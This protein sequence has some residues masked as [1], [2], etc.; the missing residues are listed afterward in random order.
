M[1]F[2][3]ITKTVHAYLDYPVAVALVAMPFILGLGQTH[4]L[5]LW[6]S[7]ATGLAAFVLTVLTNHKTGLVGVLP[8]SLHL[9]VDRIV[10]ATFVFAPI[11]FGVR[12]PDAWYYWVTGAAVLLVTCVLNVPESVERDAGLIDIRPRP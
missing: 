7:V 2:R 3:F 6:L 4:P 12:V 5:T 11:V 10:G 1:R 8:Y 9:E